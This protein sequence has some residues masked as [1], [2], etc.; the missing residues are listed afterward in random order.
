MSVSQNNNTKNTYDTIIVGAGVGGLSAAICLARAG[1]KVLVLEQ[2]DVPGGWCHSFYLN[3]YRFTPGVHYV[4]LLDKGQSTSELYEGLGIA[5]DI[6]FYKMNPKGFEHC[7]IEDERFD[8]PSN[9][10]DFQAALIER[11]PHEKKGIIK[12]LTLVKNV[13]KQL[14][15]IPKVKGLWQ[16]ITIPFRTKHMGKYSPFSLKRVINWHVK[17]PLLQSILNVQFGDHGLPPKKASF[18]MHAAIMAHYSAGGFYPMGGGGAI[19]K[20]MTNK[21]K[22][23]DGLVQTST[24]VKRILLEGDKKK[25]AIGIELESGEQ[26]FASRVISNADP[27]ITYFNLIGKDNISAKLLKKLS[28]TKYSCTSIMLFLTVDMDV[29]KAGLDSG[30]IWLLKDKDFDTIYDDSQNADILKGEEF[31]G[32]F[33]SCTTLKDPISFDGRYHTLEAITYINYDAFADFKDEDK[34][35]SEAYLQFKEQII[36]KFLRSLEKVVPGI[37]ASIVH[38]ELGTPI[39][40]EFYINSTD[41]NVYGTEKSL[42]HIGPFAYKMKSEIEN[43]YLCGASTVSHGVAGASYSGVQTAAAILGCRQDDLIKPDAAQDLRIFDA[44]DDTNYPDW[45]Q[46]KIALKKTKLASKDVFTSAN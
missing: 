13:G 46:K 7:W 8:Y 9:F 26:I 18:I 38:K 28:K 35:R 14:Q 19:V 33:I 41:G 21:I 45:M 42:K 16:Q 10:D 40:N 44:E 32:M 1:Q 23:H 37:T 36:Q 20:A 30:N 3:G 11:F 27:G 34:E 43:F 31:P 17:D 24:S 25:K 22:K 5:N 4:G 15:L 29:K 12:Y 6:A 2:H 39:T